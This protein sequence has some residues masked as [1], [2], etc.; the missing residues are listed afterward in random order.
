MLLMPQVRIELDPEAAQK[1][2]SLKIYYMMAPTE[3]CH[4]FRHEE[5]TRSLVHTSLGSII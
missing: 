4:D 1:Y 3:V 5:N 2:N